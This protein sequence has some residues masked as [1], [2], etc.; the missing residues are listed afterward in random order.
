MA[1]S[2]FVQRCGAPLMFNSCS[3]N[4]T[5]ISSNNCLSGPPGSRP[6]FFQ[7]SFS[8]EIDFVNN[9]SRRSVARSRCGFASLHRATS[10]PSISPVPYSSEG[11]LKRNLN[12]YLLDG[13]YK[14]HFRILTVQ[15]VVPLPPRSRLRS[16]MLPA[17]QR[18]RH[19]LSIGTRVQA[20]TCQPRR[21]S[22]IAAWPLH[23]VTSAKWSPT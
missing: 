8:T 7:C 23:A 15:H 21:A 17:L 1:S 14:C 13:C 4:T 22:T 5:G 2:F 12:A 16:R 19:R 18:R 6:F 10:S 9:S 20:C 11:A 3:R